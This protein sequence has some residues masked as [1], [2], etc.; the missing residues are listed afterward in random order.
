MHTYTL[1]TCIY[2]C[3]CIGLL[4]TLRLP[5]VFH[6]FLFFPNNRIDWIGAFS[7][8]SGVWKMS[9]R[10]EGGVIDG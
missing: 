6:L 2:A 10:E 3:I 1:H 7:R 9:E 5:T 4:L 8:F